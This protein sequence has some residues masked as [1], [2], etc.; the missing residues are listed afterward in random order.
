MRILL[1]TILAGPDG[2]H[3]PGDVIDVTEEQGRDLI[4]ARC[5]T[6]ETSVDKAVEVETATVEPEEKQVAVKKKRGRPRKAAK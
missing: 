5:A 1:Q 3:F 2:S 6:E 4:D